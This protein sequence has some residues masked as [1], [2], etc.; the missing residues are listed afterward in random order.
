M[1]YGYDEGLIWQYCIE[2]STYHITQLISHPIVR[3]S[4]VNYIL[5]YL[6]G[7]PTINYLHKIECKQ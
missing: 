7:K 6:I 1:P 4:T 3:I 2:K 5:S